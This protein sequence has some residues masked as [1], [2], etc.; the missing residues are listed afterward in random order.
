MLTQREIRR[1][2]RDQLETADDE[3]AAQNLM[4]MIA[5]EEIAR[6]MTQP[7][8]LSKFDEARDDRA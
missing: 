7:M 4:S 8:D 6:F 3:V 2:T 1:A 5:A